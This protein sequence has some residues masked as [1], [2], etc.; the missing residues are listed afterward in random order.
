MAKSNSP[1][2]KSASAFDH[3]FQMDR[4]RIQ[5]GLGPLA[6]VGVGAEA[7]LWEESYLG[8]LDTYFAKQPRFRN[9]TAKPPLCGPFEFEIDIPIE[10]LEH[11]LPG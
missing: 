8:Y 5:I 3:F 9:P 1:L 4:K 11:I 6:F 7:V 2:E 10:G